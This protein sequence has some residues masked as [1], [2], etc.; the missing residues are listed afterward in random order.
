MPLSKEFGKLTND[1]FARLVKTLPELRTQSCELTKI[2]QANPKRLNELLGDG[3]VSWGELYERP[4]LEQMAI[5]T[6]TPGGF[7]GICIAIWET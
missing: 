4:F 6:G 3:P 5:L 2:Y 1:Q 7:V